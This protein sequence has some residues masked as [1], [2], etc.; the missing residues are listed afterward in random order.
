M[1]VTR[2]SA[3]IFDFGDTLFYSPSGPDVL[4]GAGL[5]RS[6]AERL[7]DEIWEV[8]KSAEEVARDRDLSLERHRRAWLA[9]FERAER[10]VPGAARLLYERV[11]NHD[12]WLP[13]PDAAPVLRGL[14]DRGVRIGVLSNIPSSLETVFELHGLAGYVDVYTESYRHGATKPHPELFRIACRDLGVEPRR[15][16]M[17][18][19]NHITD[20]AAVAVGMTALILPPV[21]RGAERGLEH[22]LRLC[23]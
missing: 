10:Y 15:A 14:H 13:H 21:P 4:V 18:G 22:V 17:V 1:P 3:V 19:D 23:C 9:I 7:W 11:M 6:R 16:L 2:F 20:G 5:D 8:S 12:L